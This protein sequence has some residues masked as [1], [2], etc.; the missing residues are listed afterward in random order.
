MSFPTGYAST[1]LD[2][3]STVDFDGTAQ[4]VAA[5]NYGNLTITGARGLNNSVTLAGSGTIGVAGSFVT[6]ATFSGTGAYVAT[7]STVNFNGTSAQTIPAFNY[8]NVTSSSSGG[9]ILASS[10]IVGVAGTFAPGTNTYTITG[11]TIAFNGTTAQTIPT[12]T[13][14]NLTNTNAGTKTAGGAITVIGT[15]LVNTGSTFVASTF[16]HHFQGNFT[17]NGTL[18][19]GT[20]TATFDGTPTTLIGGSTNPTTFANLT[21]E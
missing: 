5:Q 20:S 13:Y 10:G 15:F 17:N 8:N 2:P 9:R 4:T 18:T 14:N 16:T 19:P 1:T 3:A 12:F 7:G 21:I 6:T 11:S